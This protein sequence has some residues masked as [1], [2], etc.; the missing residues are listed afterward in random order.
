VALEQTLADDRSW[1]SQGLAPGEALAHWRQWVGNTLAPTEIEASDIGSFRAHWK[2]HALGP[3]QL[4]AFEASSQRVVHPGVEYD[5]SVEPSFQLVYSRQ[6]TYQTRAGTAHFAVNPGEFVLL[7]N[8]QF[9]EMRI[10]ATHEA[11]DLVMPASWLQRYLPDPLPYLG[12]SFP[13][14][15]GWGL[16]LGSLLT[17][18]SCELN[19]SPVSRGQLAD[20]VGAMLSLALGHVPI[21]TTS[22]H[23]NKI[24]QRL[25]HL[26][27]ERHAEPELKPGDAA[28][29]LGISKRYL[30]ALL[31]ETGTTF[32]GLL[33]RVRLDHASEMLADPRFRSLQVAEIAWRCGYFDSSYFARLFGRRFGMRPSEWRAQRSS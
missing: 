1:S 6:G 12:R 22:R 16:P 4:A 25:L 11:I 8:N 5:R 13:A 2:I 20:Q 19:G 24:V 29:E 17:T 30:H 3:L 31:A 26:I 14:S 15:S 10:D 21:P 28:V 32:I 33:N 18:M 23:R 9:Y 7:D 27:E